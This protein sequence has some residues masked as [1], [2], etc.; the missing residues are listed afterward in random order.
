MYCD[1]FGLSALPFNNTPDPKFFFNTPD[2]EEALASLVYTATQR[3]GYALVT[4]EVGSGKTLLTRLLLS[5]LPV[6]AQTAVITNSRL[7]GV[8]LLGAI[9]RE[10]QISI[11]PG[12]SSADLCHALEEFLLQQYARD[13]LAIVVLD[14][15]QN[16]A[17]DAFEELRLLGNLEAEDAK[18]LQVLILGQPELRDT[19]QRSELRQLRQRVF[20]TYHLKGLTAEQTSGYVRHRL[21]VV[22]GA[23]LDLFTPAAIDAIYRASGGM[24]RLINQICDHALL[25]AYSAQSKSVTPAIVATCL[26][27][28]DVGRDLPTGDRGADKQPAKASPT[29]DVESVIG[30]LHDRL[31]HFERRIDSVAGQLKSPS[32][33]SEAVRADLAQI[34]GIREQAQALFEDARAQ[35]DVLQSRM[36]KLAVEGQ[37][38]VA[39]LRDRAVGVANTAAS[40]TQA[41]A[42]RA[43]RLRGEVVALAEAEDQGIDALS[44]ESDS[45]RKSAADRIDATLEAETSRA[46]RL[47]LSLNGVLSQSRSDIETVRGHMLHLGEKHAERVERVL[48]G[49]EAL[50]AS[51][52]SQCRTA[53]EQTARQV[54]ESQAR[55]ELVQREIDASRRRSIDEVESARGKLA[56]MLE[57]AGQAAAESRRQMEELTRQFELRARSGVR[58]IEELAAAP[59]AAARQCA[60][61]LQQSLTAAATQAAR[62]RQELDAISRA[63]EQRLATSTASLQKSLTVHRSD[64]DA[65]RQS[66]VGLHSE[67]VNKLA[68]CR[69]DAEQQMREQA[70]ATTE[71]RRET[72]Q[73]VASLRNEAAACAKRMADEAESLRARATEASKTTLAE[74]EARLD[75]AVRRAGTAQDRI[76]QSLAALERQS[77]GIRERIDAASKQSQ[78]QLAAVN[79]SA[80]TA[81]DDLASKADAARGAWRTDLANGEARMS[82]LLE[83]ARRESMT[84]ADE[85]KSLRTEV[86]AE[87][88]E[89]VGRIQSER[90]SARAAATR[91]VTTLS[92]LTE[93]A[94]EATEAAEA[95]VGK[96]IAESEAGMQR[97]ASFADDMTQRVAAALGEA[98][99]KVAASRAQHEHDSERLR[100]ELAGMIEAGRDRIAELEQRAD[101]LEPRAR[102]IGDELEQRMR[103]AQETA[104]RNTEMFAGEFARML[105]E[106]QS[107]AAQMRRELEAVQQG[108]VSAAEAAKRE[109]EDAIARRQAAVERMRQISGEAI[110]E[111]REEADRTAQQA[112]SIRLELQTSGDEVRRSVESAEDR[113]RQTATTLT[114][115]IETL[116]D[117]ARQDAEATAGRLSGLREQVEAGAEQ[118]RQQSARLL[119]QGEAASAALRQHADELMQA[120]QRGAERVAGEAKTLLSSADAAVARFDERA[121]EAVREITAQ[122]DSVK[123]EAERLRGELRAG[124]ERVEEAAVLV[125]RESARVKDEAETLL[126]RATEVEGRTTELREMTRSVAAVVKSLATAQTH[127][128]KQTE[129]IVHANAAADE[130]LA[131]ISQHTARVGQLVG[132]IRQL[133]GALDTR[134]DSLRE[135]LNAADDICRS[136]PREIETL[137]EAL[138]SPGKRAVGGQFG[139]GKAELRVGPRRGAIRVR[140]ATGPGG[141]AGEKGATLGEVIR[142]NQKLNEWLEKTVAAA[143]E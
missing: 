78:T 138:H 90:E 121:V 9:C 110:V 68:A 98:Q 57:S 133:Y 79:E 56:G 3:K 20:R 95:R 100:G 26:D 49:L 125:T 102:Q 113:L 105:G 70:Q 76:A 135:R 87:L 67:L 32:E 50:V 99:E 73:R 108:L 77:E 41:V 88:G 39:A 44:D 62:A 17:I 6:G 124:Q 114:S 85:F 25:D 80:K 83:A 51:V 12:A 118:V 123:G 33:Q 139:G 7:S 60:E 40:T 89:A 5:R 137:R 107:S 129:Q 21:S 92:R 91:M 47:E 115:Q 1:F 27:A 66:A 143:G 48:G 75:A 59:T 30:K 63:A 69:A 112:A 72:A 54:T 58:R 122:A 31:A 134:I 43:E 37:T 86:A 71:M 2:H 45:S 55:A 127:A 24:P 18:L 109:A 111:L 104:A 22:G 82:A 117:A 93:R 65:L 116:R 141:G 142:R 42:E 74:H 128:R 15:A 101:E 36:K 106:T 61:E 29:D 13:R 140:R 130:R 28:L 19:M 94:T 119:S 120:A 11:E 38:S 46:A 64:F 84:M 10:F 35:M 131:Q 97:L 8:E 132:I 23:K 16:L 52:T 34:R 53:V 4:G 136:V 96:I 103:V 14:E 126:V 81:L